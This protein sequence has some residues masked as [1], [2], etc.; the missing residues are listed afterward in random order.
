M[1][2]RN[3]LTLIS[4]V[5]FG[6]VFFITSALIYFAFYNS[7]E[8]V[9][10]NELKKTSLL[11]A[12]YY[13]EKD[14]LTQ[15]E[16]ST[17]RNEF[18]S[19]IESSMVAVYNSENQ[20]EYGKLFSDSH[21]TTEYLERVRKQ[22]KIQFQSEDHFY[23]GIYYPDNQGNFVVF[24]KASN[25]EFLAQ[26]HRLLL[27]MIVV[28][29]AGLAVIFALSKNLSN[30][31][32]RP[33]SKVVKQINQI[34]DTNLGQAITPPNTNDEV[35]ELIKTYNKLFARLSETFLIQ[36]NFINYVSHEFKTPL[37]A[38]A[39]NL[40]VFAQKDRTAAE[41]K[42]VA[43][44]AL[45]NVYKIEDLLSNLLLMSGLKNQATTFVFFR[46]DEVIWNVYEALQEKSTFLE[47]P[48]KID[49]QVLHPALLE[50]KGNET[51]IQLALF[52]L[53]ENALKYSNKQP[54]II[55]ILE[56]GGRLTVEIR[57]F[58]QG[59]APEDL[60]LIGQTFY[61][62]KN[63][64]RIPGSGIG[65]SLAKTILDQHQITFELESELQRGTTVRLTFDQTTTRS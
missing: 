60:S 38:I 26:T 39:G 33:I 16:H 36:K 17:I 52:N 56:I 37:A 46:I 50:F 13:L 24:V 12:F 45:E 40:E 41:Y 7:S 55:A 54:V 57:D 15:I 20:V 19:T 8:R 21:I 2:L 48:I 30:L 18:R 22:Q 10:F 27:I 63:V 6:V 1:K 34:D 11:S 47:V 61:R 31:A 42:K 23:Y 64:G 28:L 9:F 62:G 43:D 58:G 4:T 44:D 49:L 65:L 29:L 35:D 53:V 5:T 32:Y 3:R 59:I 14:E 25:S 51:L